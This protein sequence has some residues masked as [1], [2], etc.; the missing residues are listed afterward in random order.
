MDSA[1]WNIFVRDATIW[2]KHAHMGAI[3][4]N[5]VV[6]D[7][8]HAKKWGRPT[9]R[10][11]ARANTG[12]VDP[13]LP[14]K[15]V[16]PF[17]TSL[18]VSWDPGIGNGNIYYIILHV[19]SGLAKR[20]LYASYYFVIADAYAHVWRERCTSKGKTSETSTRNSK[21]RTRN[22][23]WHHH[24]LMAAPASHPYPGFSFP[25]RNTTLMERSEPIE[26]NL[27]T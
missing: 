10:V 22:V 27:E 6:I 11:R 7:C 24:M 12:F 5:P 20:I 3:S 2:L 14:R 8:T 21:S 19:F 17:D 4:P 13:Y 18:F 9:Q 15:N 26:S 25:F 1:S 16:R 23:Q